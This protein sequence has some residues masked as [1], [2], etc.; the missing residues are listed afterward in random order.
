MNNNCV[1]YNTQHRPDKARAIL[2]GKYKCET[3]IYGERID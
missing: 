1:K 2:A 3:E